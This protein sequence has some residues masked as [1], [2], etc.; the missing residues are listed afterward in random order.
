M[1]TPNPTQ[2][3]T[4]HESPGHP[5]VCDNISI[6]KKGRKQTNWFVKSIKHHQIADKIS[7]K[8]FVRKF[9]IKLIVVFLCYFSG[10]ISGQ[11]WKCVVYLSS[12]MMFGQNKSLSKANSKCLHNI[13][14]EEE[15][16]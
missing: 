7:C 3:Q 6:S 8:M 14:S 12:K 11:V 1:I 13:L 15:I 5:L 10:K 4:N 9:M 2:I 16:K